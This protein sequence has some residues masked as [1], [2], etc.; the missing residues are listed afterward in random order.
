MKFTIGIIERDQNPARSCFVDLAEALG[1]ALRRLGHAVTGFDDP[2]RLIMFG[3]QNSVPVGLPDDA[4][5]YN[6]EQMTAF[7]NPAALMQAHPHYSNRV[8]WDY[9]QKNIE[10]LTK[11]GLRR[12]VHCPVGYVPEMTRI[13]PVQP[14]DL[15]VLFYGACNTRRKR[16]MERLDD[17]G[18]KIAI[19]S[20]VFGRDLDPYIARAKVVLNM[21]FYEHAVFEVVR[22]SHLWANKKCVVT[23]SGGLD[24][25]LESL[26]R[27][28]ASYVPY[29]KLVER[30][31][32]LVQDEAA[33]ERYA[34]QGFEAFKAVDF[35]ESVRKALAE[36]G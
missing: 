8:V 24:D 22:C 28:A 11:L 9:S 36:S 15:D 18:Y 30:C 7:D 25:E 6:T 12:L 4:I 27:R 34:Q 33:R 10:K 23:E 2:G 20:G 26:A 13:E 14:E 32:E 1:A 3:T 5:L 35:V 31:A 16:V 17:E 21:H 29:E 19:G